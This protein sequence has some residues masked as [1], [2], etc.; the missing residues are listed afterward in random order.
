MTTRK[1]YTEDEVLKALSK[2][3]DVRVNRTTKEIY[4][5]TGSNP[6]YPKNNDLGNSSW[7]KIDFL[8]NYAGYRLIPTDKL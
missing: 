2:K 7:G 1:F 3:R 8:T 4:F 5:L 6:H